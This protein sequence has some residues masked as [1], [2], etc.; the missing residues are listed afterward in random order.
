MGPRPDHVSVA[1]YEPKALDVPGK[2]L[3]GDRQLKFLRP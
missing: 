1:D 2:K 3:L